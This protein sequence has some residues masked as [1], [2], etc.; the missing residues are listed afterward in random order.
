MDVKQFFPREE[1]DHT[2]RERDGDRDRDG[3]EDE[4]ND[5][6]FGPKSKVPR[7]RIILGITKYIA[8]QQNSTN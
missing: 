5:H 2:Q 6:V 8:E 7:C 3:D 4:D 1:W